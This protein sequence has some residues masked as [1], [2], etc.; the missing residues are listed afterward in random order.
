MATIK[1]SIEL[2][3]A[4]TAPMM[5][6]IQA[7]NMG[8]SAMENLQQ[9]MNQSVDTTSIDG[10]RDALNQATEAAQA[11]EAAM[12]GMDIPEQ[13]NPLQVPVQPEIPDPI[14]PPSDP[15]TVPV[16]WQSENFESFLSS[17]TERFQQEIQS[18]NSMMD[19]LN[20]KQAQIAATAASTSVLPSNAVTDIN[21]VG[22][23]LQAVQQ[24]IQQIENN[25]L[26]IGTDTANAALE[27]MRGQLAQALEAQ[28]DLNA[29]LD[30]MDVSAA[31][32]AYMRLSQSVRTT[33][34]YIRDNVSAQGT[35]N[36]TVTEGIGIA[37]SLQRTIS[38]VIAAYTG[39]AGIQKA[40]GF[41]KN[42]TFLYDTQLNGE[43]QLL[44][45]LAN[46]LDEETVAK[47]A[48]DVD[49]SA[50]TTDAVNQINGIQDSVTGVEVPVSAQTDALM[51]AYNQIADKATEI[52]G[53][54]IYGD[55]AMIAAGAEFATYF[56]DTD[57]V[58]KMMDTLSDYAM[59]MSGG[60][61][62]DSTALVD[63]ATGLGKIMTGAYDAMNEK[64][65]EFSD[66]QKA[67]INGT[68]TQAQIVQT[69]GA[70]Y[71]DASSDMQAAA[72]ISQVIEE[73][74]AGLYENMSQTPE[75]KIIQLTNAWGDLEEELGGILY[76]AVLDFLNLFTENW[77]E[78]S[79]F[80][81][82]FANGLAILVELATQLVNGALLVASAFQD[83]WGW[84]APIVWGIVAAFTAYQIALGVVNGIQAIH[85]AQLGWTAVQAYKA[86]AA[87]TTLAAAEQAKAMAAAAAT[88]AQYGFNAALLACPVTWIVAAVLALIVILYAL[89]GI[90]N[91]VAG[92]SISA[93]GLITG[94]VAVAGA[95]ILNIGIGLYNSFVA[96][97][98]AFVNF[99]IGI[100]EWVLNA[101][102]GGFNSFGDAVANLIGQIINWFLS[103]G[104]IVTTIIDAIFGTDW[105][106]GLEGLKNSVTQW[107]KNENAITLDR[108]DTSTA[109]L[110]RFDY[111]DAASA[112]YDFGAGLESK[113]GNLFN[114]SG[115]IPSVEDYASLIADNANLSTLP[116]I[117]D[118]AGKIKDTLSD[119]DED[120][121]YLRDMA[122]MEVI[123]RFTTAEVKVDM[124]GMQNN[125]SNG[126]DL[127]GVTSALTDGIMEAIE[128]TAEG[129]HD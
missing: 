115:S 54:G 119:T 70:E 39:I 69:L 59:G 77:D 112:G 30:N 17:G 51:D 11:L 95:F 127:D 111:G 56:T 109:G 10:A 83:N 37:D 128:V 40:I 103:L 14:V 18:A 99:F 65:F 35:F 100:I 90:I 55:E 58:T 62:L 97:I 122:E 89:V 12:Q 113:V 42:T 121:K 50:D 94:A 85:N 24:R 9:G 60:G 21:N 80:C 96:V 32:Q 8:M 22:S 108:M 84:I 106:A 7:V 76:P 101:A 46:S 29:A 4:F 5:D 117:A 36:N 114:F 126:M 125:I 67:I 61:A 120:L 23:R 64:G 82:M 38:G 123:N 52:Q 87:N 43:V 63:Y 1:S 124:S 25:P 88:A 110:Q 27:Q 16:Q 31:N 47:Y 105:T 71:A 41:I 79:E 48:V 33:E 78:V 20:Q 81:T 49:V 34:T 45:V 129:V 74:W 118:N 86:A 2:Y 116:D 72:T 19:S 92:T 98:A 44:S 66:T 28:N 102:N 107:G 104:Q 53:K 26:N 93:T 13:T 91:Q 15:V 3:D 73:S 68:A 57:A 75:G 6:I